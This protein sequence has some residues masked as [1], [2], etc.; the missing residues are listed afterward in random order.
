MD[1]DTVDA[2]EERGLDVDKG[3][4]PLEITRYV[5][6]EGSRHDHKEVADELDLDEDSDIV[7]AI[8]NVGCQLPRGQAPRLIGGLIASYP[9]YLGIIL[10][11]VAGIHE[12]ATPI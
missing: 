9:T 6:D 1:R 5:H 11:R 12:S 2:I 4:Y 8:A 3:D 10:Y 7:S